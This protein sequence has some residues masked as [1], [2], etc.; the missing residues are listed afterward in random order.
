M[1]KGF[2]NIVLVIAIILLA[3]AGGY[4]ALTKKSGLPKNGALNDHVVVPV[5]QQTPATDSKI[6]GWKTYANEKYGYSLSYPNNWIVDSEQRIVNQDNDIRS[7]VSIHNS[8]NSLG[9]S[10]RVDLEDSAIKYGA[11]QKSQ[12]SI[13]GKVETAYLFPTGYECGMADPTAK[14]CSFF[15]VSFQKNGFWYTFTATGH[16]ES[17]A[18]PYVS[19]FSSTKFT[20]TGIKADKPDIVSADSWKS[21]SNKRYNYSFKYP[22]GAI[23]EMASANKIPEAC[24]FIKY[25]DAFVYIS[26]PKDSTEAPC[27]PTG[28]GLGYAPT[29][30]DIDVGKIPYVAEGFK[31]SLQQLAVDLAK[32]GGKP[33]PNDK[34]ET[35]EWFDIS[36]VNGNMR[37]V[38][39]INSG[40][41]IKLT[42]YELMEKASLIRS[43]LRS[44]TF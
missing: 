28:V 12:I 31:Y 8:D 4:L 34:D 42:N 29:K 40:L 6:S 30:E 26:N 19:I 32:S 7:L 17:V 38:Y 3:G 25:K 18:E 15:M 10:V 43:I 41:G 21:Y 36:S 14:D 2:I 39:G 16:A 22:E 13:N 44:L 5:A 11:L 20:N 35:N 27:G 9:V 24:L 33:S 23:I 37:V 1:K